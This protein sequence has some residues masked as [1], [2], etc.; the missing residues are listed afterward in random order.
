[1]ATSYTEGKTI[2]DVV[3][4]QLP[5][6]FCCE[7]VTLE[8]AEQVYVGSPLDKT[9]GGGGGAIKIT[10]GNEANADAIS[11]EAK[12]DAGSGTDTVLA[13]VRGPAIV[14]A[15]Q[16]TL[17][18]SVTKAELLSVFEALNILLRDEPS[19]TQEGPIES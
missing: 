18:T 17:E 14:N 15:D 5:H 13:L 19:L 4:Y 3:R 8:D 7:I 12:T 11:L 16:L 2:G 10:N 9:G 6:G 1:M